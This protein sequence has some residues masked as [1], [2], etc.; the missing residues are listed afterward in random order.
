MFSVKIYSWEDAGL[1]RE[2]ITEMEVGDDVIVET[3]LGK[4]L[5]KVVKKTEKASEKSLNKIK[6][7]RFIRK[8]NI[9]DIIAS[10]KHNAKRREAKKYFRNVSVKYNLPMKIVDVH[11]GY[12]G[13]HVVFVFICE[14][15][16]DFRE[17]VK[18]LSRKFQ[19]SVRLQQ[20]GSRDNTKKYKCYGSCGR[21][22]C[23]RFLCSNLGGI[24]T[25]MA[26]V[27]KLEHRNSERISGVCGRLMCCLAYEAEQY[28]EFYKKAPLLGDKVSLKDGD[29]G[30]VTNLFPIK[31]LVEIELKNETKVKVDLNDLK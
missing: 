2:S 19:K 5:G 28:E 26:K 14:M 15:K 10:K 20:I 31:N 27:Q 23:C 3:D 16:V 30:I 22:L 4:E 9:R 25:N 18:D 29:K 6:E 13:S 7:C 24:N 8:A 11:F 21:E 1:C 12:E 17:M